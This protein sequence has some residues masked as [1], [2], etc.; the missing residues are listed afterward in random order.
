MPVRATQTPLVTVH[1]PQTQRTIPKGILLNF[2]PRWRW[3]LTPAS[4]LTI[5]T[6]DLPQSQLHFVLEWMLGGGDNSSGPSSRQ[7]PDA[8]IATMNLLLGF[9]E[10]LEIRPLVNRVKAVRNDML[11]KTSQDQEAVQ[12]GQANGTKFLIASVGDVVETYVHGVRSLVGVTS[13]AGLITSNADPPADEHAAKAA[14]IETKAP[15]ES[16][17]TETDIDKE[18]ENKKAIQKSAR[19]QPVITTSTAEEKDHL[20]EL[21]AA[22]AMRTEEEE[23]VT[24]AEESG[25]PIEEGG[26]RAIKKL[27]SKMLVYHGEHLTVDE[28]AAVRELA[29]EELAASHLTIAAVDAAEAEF[30]AAQASADR[31]GAEELAEDLAAEMVAADVLADDL[32][33]EEQLAS[34]Q[35]LA[36]D[37]ASESLAIQT[38]DRLN[39][40]QGFAPPPSNDS[41]MEANKRKE[42]ARSKPNMQE[43]EEEE[44]LRKAIALSIKHKADPYLAQHDRIGAL[45]SHSSRDPVGINSPED[46]YTPITDFE[47]SPDHNDNRDAQAQ[48]E[49]EGGDANK[50][51][52]STTSDKKEIKR[53]AAEGGR[54]PEQKTDANNN[55]QKLVIQVESSKGEGQKGKQRASE[56]EEIKVGHIAGGDDNAEELTT[57]RLDHTH[58]TS[59]STSAKDTIGGSARLHQDSIAPDVSRGGDTEDWCIREDVD[60]EDDEEVAKNESKAGDRWS[61]TRYEMT[62]AQQNVG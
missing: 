36:Q 3:H 43:K 20:P 52:V 4:T 39:S 57:T 16:P 5:R 45:R 29:A 44:Q 55:T 59:G 9:V 40:S 30:A 24:A 50:A 15:G 51:Q 35:L 1:G 18:A 12:A 53:E 56:A 37:L 28:L 25:E 8:D 10:A 21:R 42:E 6:Q 62:G 38:H 33:A 7:I 22:A 11:L 17:S 31:L 32:A 46:R 2:A 41:R 13:A 34:D 54:D 60:D 58:P 23:E 47:S 14:K 61:I 49:S 26:E 48:K 27:T 19:E